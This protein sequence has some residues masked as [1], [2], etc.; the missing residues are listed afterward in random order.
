[1]ENTLGGNWTDGHSDERSDTV[2]AF[3]GTNESC[4]VGQVEGRAVV[5]RRSYVGDAVMKH[6]TYGRYVLKAYDW[7]IEGM[8]SVDCMC[9]TINVRVR[10]TEASREFAV[11]VRAVWKLH[12]GS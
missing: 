7:L 2:C 6:A 12:G 8:T 4:R 11:E 10:D 3:T 5:C 1:M 9:V